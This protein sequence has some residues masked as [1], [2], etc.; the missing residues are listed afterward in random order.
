MTTTQSSQTISV[1]EQRHSLDS[2]HIF[3][4]FPNLFV[5]FLSES[6]ILNP[7]YKEVRSKSEET[8]IRSEVHHSN[9]HDP[10]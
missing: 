10:S 2:E 3:V 7:Y 4:S 8:V 5:S 9:F 1:A 6:P